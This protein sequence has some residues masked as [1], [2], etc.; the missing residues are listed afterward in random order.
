MSGYTLPAG[1]VLLAIVQAGAPITGTF[2]T[3][4]TTTDG[5]TFTPHPLASQQ[6]VSV[7]QPIGGGSTSVLELTLR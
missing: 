2:S 6:V 4:Q 5:V 1:G 3:V 7:N